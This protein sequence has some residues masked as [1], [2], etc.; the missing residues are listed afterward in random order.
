MGHCQTHD[1]GK[2]EIYVCVHKQKSYLSG[3]PNMFSC[4]RFDPSNNSWHEIPL[5]PTP[6]DNAA[7]AFIQDDIYVIDGDVINPHVLHITLNWHNVE[8][9]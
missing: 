4:E 7:I 3:F 9:S 5:T 2:V 1:L 8:K 6:S